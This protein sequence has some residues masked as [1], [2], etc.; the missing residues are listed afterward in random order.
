M[1]YGNGQMLAVIEPPIQIEHRLKL[2]GMLG[3]QH[4]DETTLPVLRHANVRS[5]VRAAYDWFRHPVTSYGKALVNIDQTL[6][7]TVDGNI[8]WEMMGDILYGSRTING[9]IRQQR[10]YRL[11][12]ATDGHVIY[13]YSK[14]IHT[15]VMAANV[16]LINAGNSPV[17]DAMKDCAVQQKLSALLFAAQ[18]AITSR[19]NQIT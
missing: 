4:D 8:N 18:R 7:D 1:E 13:Q 15:P 16:N 9:L 2:A 6:Q 12:I 10:T 19:P 11:E 5:R 17:R 3:L 14:F